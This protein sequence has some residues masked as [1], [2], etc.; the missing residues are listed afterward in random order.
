MDTE[1]KDENLTPE[2][3]IAEK[4]ILADTKEDEV[5]TKI[6]TDLG[7]SEDDNAELI[8]KLTA[9]EIEQRKK[10]S[11]AV[12]QKISWREQAKGASSGK[13]DAPKKDS[14]VF[15]PD[16]IRK[17]AE[18]AALRTLE[19]RDLDEM[20][21]SDEVKAEIKKIATLNNVSVRKAA[22]DPYIKHVIAEAEKKAAIDEAA[23]NGSK[24]GKTGVKID[25]SKPLDPKDFD[26]H[27]EEG[28]K[29]WDEAKQARREAHK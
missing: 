7:L 5:R 16:A 18:S 23:S 14:N 1:I 12:R 27:T 22:Q 26:L 19:Q 20:E 11:T 13:K 24:R 17:E 8:E 28:R 4:E 10:L 29:A 9:R 15:D 21:Y 3:Q 2:E 6:I 25:V